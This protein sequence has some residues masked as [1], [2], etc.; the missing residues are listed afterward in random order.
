MRKTH[1]L[2]F[3]SILSLFSNA[4]D[5][6]PT[7][8][9]SSITNSP[10]N[11][12]FRTVAYGNDIF[13]FGQQAYKYSTTN[14]T[15]ES[16]ANMP[17]VRGDIGAAEVGGKI[18]CLGGY[19]GNWSNKNE[20]YN[21]ATNTWEVKANLPV[22]ISG[23]HAV[24]L[25][26]K[27]YVFGGTSGVTVSH[28]YEYNTSTNTYTTLNLP[29]Q[30]RMH[31][32]LVVHNDKIYLVGG[33][34]FN[35]NYNTIT[36][37]DEYD[38][39]TNSWT[40]KANLPIPTQLTNAVVQN[41]KL[42][43]F[44]GTQNTPNWLPTNNFLAYD[45]QADTW[46]IMPNMPFSRAYLDP[47]SIN[48]EI[49]LFGGHISATTLTNQCHK[50]TCVTCSDVTVSDTQTVFVSDMAFET[51]SPRIYYE[52]TENLLTTIGGCDSI[53][54]HY[55]E[56]VFNPSYCT[57]TVLIT[58]TDTLIINYNITS[59]NPLSYESTIKIY[60]NPTTEY[61]TIDY[62]NL[63]VFSGFGLIIQNSLGEIVF[64]E[65]IVQD[66]STLSMD[67]IGSTGVY[68]VHLQN[69]QGDIIETRKIVVQ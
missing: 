58:V 4:Q 20:A 2:L 30:Q 60:P 47:K 59:L 27:I 15:W 67:T 65:S 54:N 57:E 62:G 26:D 5:I 13:A 64:S 34:F 42:F 63:D 9:F 45:L 56:Y 11:A 8:A 35:G 16:I 10:I 12:G 37:L 21:I 39:S 36:N 51:Q 66:T 6:C 32:G 17:T 44:G 46:T 29:S 18:Y 22:A 43:L 28:F 38:P 50:Y 48:N 25:N 33:Y 41:G 14:D 49:F 52:S 3:F 40:P 7:G 1:L 31:A 68:F 61:L 23:C 69:P 53:I 24:A 19:T 55:T